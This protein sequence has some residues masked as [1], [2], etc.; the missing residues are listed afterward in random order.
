MPSTPPRELGAE[1]QTRTGYWIGPEFAQGINGKRLLVLAEAI[2]EEAS[3]FRVGRGLT[4]DS[5]AG[6]IKGEVKHRGLTDLARLVLGVAAER[7]ECADF[8]VRTALVNLPETTSGKRGVATETDFK[9]VTSRVAEIVEALRPQLVLVFGQRLFD[10]AQAASCFEGTDVPVVW[11]ATHP[12]VEG[13]AFR[14]HLDETRSLRE[15][16]ALS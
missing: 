16:F 5:V 7:S 12:L 8:F 15:C 9:G 1:L 10:Q 3:A 6:Y 4:A 13:F 14:E 11:P 2:P